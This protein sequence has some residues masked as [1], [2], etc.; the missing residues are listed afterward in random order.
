M[1]RQRLGR[2]SSSY[3]LPGNV[4]RERLEVDGRLVLV[5]E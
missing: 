1:T 2:D 5:W 4:S 3:L